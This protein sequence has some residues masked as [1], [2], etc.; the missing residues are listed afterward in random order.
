M[1]GLSIMWDFYNDNY[2]LLNR[3]L[4]ESSLTSLGTAICNYFT[5]EADKQKVFILILLKVI[6]F[7]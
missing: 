4:G 2:L 5:E 6:H 7:L 1:D 3:R